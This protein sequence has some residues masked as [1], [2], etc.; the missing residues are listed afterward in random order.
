M[1]VFSDVMCETSKDPSFSK[2]KSS[3]R[4]CNKA[5]AGG[6]IQYGLQS[7]KNGAKNAAPRGSSASECERHCQTICRARWAQRLTA[8]DGFGVKCFAFH[9]MVLVPRRLERN[10]SCLMF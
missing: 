8:F 2:Q 7:K 5:V 9:S 3:E 4:S 10:T 6:Q 1:D